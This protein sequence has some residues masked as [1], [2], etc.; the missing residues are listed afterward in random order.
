MTTCQPST[1]SK[2]QEQTVSVK[3]RYRVQNA[4]DSYAVQVEL[5]G[6]KKENLTINL[7]QNVLTVRGRRST[8]VPADWKPLHR[9]LSDV[10]YVLK[11][12]LNVPV[13][14]AKLSAK[15]ADGILDL[16]LPVKETAK[17]RTI[18]VS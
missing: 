1:Q 2:T 14:D 5:P 17:P 4:T 3:P 15:L 6:V 13:E 16:N 8:A 9:E 11:L 10:D 12:H 7:D 18:P